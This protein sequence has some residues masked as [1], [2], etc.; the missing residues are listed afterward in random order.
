MTAPTI[1]RQLFDPQTSTYTYLLGDT[2]TGE[3][4]L[5]D[6]VLEQ[7]DRDV[8]LL[9]ELGLTLRYTLDT[10]MH[11]DHISG[12]GQLRERLGSRSVA[13]HAA[14]AACVDVAV[15]SGDEIVIGAVR[16]EVRATPGHT[17]GCVTYVE[18]AAG[19]A[20]TGDALLVR[21]T[22]RT[23]FQQ[24]DAR[25]LYRS[26]AEQIF[27]LPESFQVWPGHDYRGQTVSTVGEEK[28]HNPRLAGKSEE[29]FVEILG[30]LKLPRPRRMDEAVPANLQCGR[31]SETAQAAAAPTSSWAPVEPTPQG[32]PEVAAS[33]AG[34]NLDG[35]RL[36]DVREVHELAGDLPQ[37]SVAYCIP[38][39]ELAD[40]VADWDRDLPILLV[41]RSGRRSLSA[42]A[43]L[44]GRGFSRVASIRGGMVALSQTVTADPSNGRTKTR[45]T[46]ELSC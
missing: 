44:A 16:L 36:V 46:T 20:F 8:K 6:P 34:Q 24:G 13:A 18:H 43:T 22:G 33:W 12:S 35:V 14:G 5:I 1:F 10:H 3:A 30:N 25:M 38:L 45:V 17:P 19:R 11:A 41:C 15:H 42:A 32:T 4:L 7:V 23:D 2:R 39:A 28:R 37:L 27:S 29:E 31:V 9:A 21:G 26:I 40:R